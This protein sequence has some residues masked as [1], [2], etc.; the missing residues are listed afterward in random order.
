MIDVTVGRKNFIAFLNKEK[1]DRYWINGNL[2]FD[3]CV[4]KIYPYDTTEEKELAHEIGRRLGVWGDTSD[5]EAVVLEL[6]RPII[7][8]IT[9]AE[10]A[11]VE[12][13]VMAKYEEE[14]KVKK[15]ALFAEKK[16][17]KDEAAAK[18]AGIELVT[19]PP[20]VESVDISDK[21]SP[22]PKKI[23]VKEK[24]IKVKSAVSSAEPEKKIEAVEKPSKV[25]TPVPVEKKIE[26]SVDKKSAKDKKTSDKAEKPKEKSKL[27]KFIKP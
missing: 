25:K 6:K 4:P 20:A 27:S 7:P 16:R 21:V 15:E 13:E 19:I 8:I 3:D 24:T 10:A 26:P 12:D 14:A 18:A 22:E 17:K 5:I 9:K 1:R 2:V 23:P 11:I